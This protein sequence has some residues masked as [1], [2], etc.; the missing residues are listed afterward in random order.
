MSKFINFHTKLYELKTF[1]AFFPVKF[2][3][4]VIGF[5]NR[6]SKIAAAYLQ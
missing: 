2:Q 3:M 6:I 4:V 1:I 5:K